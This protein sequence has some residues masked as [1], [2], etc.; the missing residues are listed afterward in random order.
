MNTLRDVH[1]WHTPADDPNSQSAHC[2]YPRQRSSTTGADRAALSG[3]NYL[4]SGLDVDVTAKD[5]SAVSYPVDPD[6]GPGILLTI[7]RAAALYPSVCR[8][9]SPG[10]VPYAE[11]HAREA[12]EI[13]LAGG[14]IRKLGWRIRP[15]PIRLHRPAHPARTSGDVS[16]IH[17]PHRRR[18]GDLA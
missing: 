6:A 15:A 17:V 1:F 5:G 7:R 13:R 3:R 8:G 11:K 18:G 12:A 4:P 10:E 16:R 2:G 9:S 14:R